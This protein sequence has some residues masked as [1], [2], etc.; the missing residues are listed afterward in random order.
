MVHLRLAAVMHR[1][2]LLGP[3]AFEKAAGENCVFARSF[4]SLQYRAHQTAGNTLSHR[5][6]TSIVHDI[7]VL[8]GS[9][10][11]IN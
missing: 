3:F 1:G 2:T 9:N 7:N 10:N 11:T 5:H 6:A 4:N 8:Y